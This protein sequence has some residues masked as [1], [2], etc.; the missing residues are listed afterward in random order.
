MRGKIRLF[1]SKALLISFLLAIGTVCLT[2]YLVEVPFHKSVYYNSFVSL[3]ILSIIFFCFLVYGLYHGFDVRSTVR[4]LGDKFEFVEPSPGP[5]P[6][7]L[8]LP[9]AP[10]FGDGIEG[11]VAGILLWIGMAILTFLLLFFPE[12]IIWAGILIAIGSIHWIFYRALR[13]VLKRSGTTRGNLI[14]SVRVSAYY[15]LIYVGW[16]YATVYTLYVVRAW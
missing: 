13:L 6:V 4:R 5:S 11:I 8:V 1:S 10:D 16:I 9:D 14:R 15:T 3:S 12:T 7:N 2:V